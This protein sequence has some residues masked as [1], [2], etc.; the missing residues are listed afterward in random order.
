[1]GL[2]VWQTL[3]RTDGGKGPEHD[4]GRGT[5]KDAL[6]LPSLT[7]RTAEDVAH[8]AS[9][10][11]QMVLWGTVQDYGGGAIVEAY[12]SLPVYARLNDSYFADF[13]RERKEE[14]VVRARAGARQV[15]F[16]RDVPRRR[17]AFE[18]I[19]IAPA[20]VRNYSSYDALQLYDPADPSKPIG[21]IGNDITGVEQHGDSAIV[22]TRGVKGIVRLPQ[23]SANRSEVVDFVGGLM[24]IF[25]GDWAGAEQLMR[26]VAENRNALAMAKLGRSG[27]DHIERAL[28]LNPYAERTAAFAIMDVLERLARLTERDAAASERRDLIAQVRQRV[29]R[30]RRLFLADDPWINGVLAGLKTIEDSL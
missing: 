15:E 3:R 28:E 11:S 2:Q 20:V 7:H 27:E 16:R 17:I 19:V 9:F 29:E 30:H 13:R 22:T 5:V 6:A 23:L 26:G 8:H 21:P 14:W 12:L 4:F 24:R 10:L 18:P 25:R 1:M